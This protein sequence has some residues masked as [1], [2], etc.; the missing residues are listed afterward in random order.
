MP[1]YINIPGSSSGSGSNEEFTALQSAVNNNSSN[2]AALAN[3]VYNGG[4]F[5]SNK[6]LSGITMMT[7]DSS[8]YGTS[9]PSSGTNGQV[10]F[11][12]P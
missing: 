6:T 4:D 3:G 1:I 8:C 10:F 12:L 7:F 11:L 2:V 5:I 9:L